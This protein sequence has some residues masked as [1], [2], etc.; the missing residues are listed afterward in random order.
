MI[1]EDRIQVCLYNLN[2]ALHNNE[3]FVWPIP[4]FADYPVS[5]GDL[6]H[7]IFE[8]FEIGNNLFVWPALHVGDLLK[9]LHILDHFDCF[10][11]LQKPCIGFLANACEVAVA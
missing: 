2:L 9:E 5:L 10:L 1:I 7:L 8:K 3:E 11:F 4:F 6:D